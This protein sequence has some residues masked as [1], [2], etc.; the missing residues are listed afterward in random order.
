MI[1]FQ[2]QIQ[3]SFLHL[4]LLNTENIRICLMKEIQESFLNAC[5]DTIYIPRY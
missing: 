4:R 2:F 5:P 1:P 3:L